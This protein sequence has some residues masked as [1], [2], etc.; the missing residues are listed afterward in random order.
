MRRLGAPVVHEPF[1]DGD[2]AAGFQRAKRFLEQLAAAL[3]AFAVQNMAQRRDIVA[4]AKICFQQIA[5]NK[6]ESIA[7]AKLLRDTF[8]RGNHSGPIDCGHS[9]ARRFLCQCNS[10]DAG[11]GGEI[12]H[13]QFIFCFRHFQVI[14][15]FLCAAVAHGDDILDELT[16]ELCA[17]GFFIHGNYRSPVAH[18]IT[19]P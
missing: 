10:P 17:F 9:H 2:C 3:F 7:D 4:V 15:E 11:S 12:E 19:Q 5:S 16:E 18:G 8:G 14:R 6:F 13:A 1:S